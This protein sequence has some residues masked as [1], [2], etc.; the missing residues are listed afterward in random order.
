MI[1]LS[2]AIAQI[3]ITQKELAER[4]GVAQQTVSNWV[5]G[6]SEP[7]ASQLQELS[8]LSGIDAMDILCTK[9]SK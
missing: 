3:G 7:S 4:F 5:N 9:T 8:R 2:A 1:K 6:V